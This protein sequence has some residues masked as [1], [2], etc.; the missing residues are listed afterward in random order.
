MSPGTRARS[1]TRD[2]ILERAVD[3]ASIEG[4]EGLT[5]GR[6]ATE[7]GMSKSGLFG[8]FG[9]KEELQ[10]A[11][12][13]AADAVLRRE[14]IEPATDLESGLQRLRELIERYVRYLEREVFPGGCFISAAAAEFDGRPGQV[15]DAI[16]VASRAW[17]NELEGQAGVAVAKGELPEGTDPTQLAFELNA[18][19]DGANAVYQLHRDRSAFE[20]ARTAIARLLGGAGNAPLISTRP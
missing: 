3:L 13:E 7:L 11:T 20:R 9:S 18:L 12:L 10:L 6:L 17:G 5:I 4:L 19:A 1:R 15:R 14:F 16:A 2:A 8:H